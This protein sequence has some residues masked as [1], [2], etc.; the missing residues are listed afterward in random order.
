MA[1]TEDSTEFW[2]A[3]IIKCMTRK[4]TYDKPIVTY[5]NC[6]KLSSGR[7]AYFFNQ[8]KESSAQ[9]MAATK[10]FDDRTACSTRTETKPRT[11]NPA[12]G[13]KGAGLL[14]SVAR[15]KMLMAS[16]T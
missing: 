6:R 9:Q 3:S 1:R 2:C 16:S 13:R 4:K 7:N 10:S 14:E 8:K 5:G 12:K 15:N 11:R